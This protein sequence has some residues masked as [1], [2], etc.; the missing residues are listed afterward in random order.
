VGRIGEVGPPLRG[1]P[2]S[3]FLFAP[4]ALNENPAL[5]DS[6]RT[7]R[8]GR[9]KTAAKTPENHNHNRKQTL[10]IKVFCNP[11]E[12]QAILDKA[13]QCG[14]SASHFLRSIGLGLGVVSM[15]DHRQ[16]DELIRINGDLGR[17]GGLLKLYLNHDDKLKINSSLLLKD[18]LV[19]TL[20]DIK[21]N[22]ASLKTIIQQVVKS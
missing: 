18:A 4:M 6:F 14:L 3:H 10:P 1:G 15:I 20:A 5:R 7:C 21:T 13:D 22:Q 19:E 17:L 16:V 9:M 2:T 11:V 8:G 12:R